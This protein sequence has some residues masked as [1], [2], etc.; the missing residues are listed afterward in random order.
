MAGCVPGSSQKGDAELT[1]QIEFMQILVETAE[2]N[3][4]LD[5]SISLKEL[6]PEN[7]LYAELGDGYTETMYW[8]KQTV[9]MLPVLFLCRHIDQTRCIDQLASICNYFQRLKEYPRGQF[10]SWLDT[11]IAKEP[12]K[13]GRD[14][15]GMYHYSCI[16]NCKLYF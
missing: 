4:N 2:Q 5:S 16:L 14:E 9:R 7:S 13:I 15:D 11:T 1:P 8:D 3:C 6:S 12:S 10:F